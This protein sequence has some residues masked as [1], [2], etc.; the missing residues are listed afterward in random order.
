MK[1]GD[2]VCSKVLGIRG[3]IKEIKEGTNFSSILFEYIEW[4]N[5]PSS[6]FNGVIKYKPSTPIE[7]YGNPIRVIFDSDKWDYYV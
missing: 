6:S 7:I 4:I 3:K 1:I 5:S 2:I